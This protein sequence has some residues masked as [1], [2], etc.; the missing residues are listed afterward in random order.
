M[1]SGLPPKARFLFYWF[2]KFIEHVCIKEI[3]SFTNIL[4]LSVYLTTVTVSLSR[5]PISCPFSFRLSLSHTHARARARAHT[6]QVNSVVKFLTHIWEVSNF[7][8]CQGL[9]I[10]TDFFGFPAS[11][12]SISH[13]LFHIPSVL[14]FM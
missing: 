1:S 13:E 11:L 14:P 7:N 6:R 3:P 2:F 12:L 5:L 9:S 4:F 8:S 10:L